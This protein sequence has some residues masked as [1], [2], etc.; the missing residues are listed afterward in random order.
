MVSVGETEGQ[1]GVTDDQAVS[2]Q[3]KSDW[4]K[5]DGD[6]KPWKL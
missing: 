2:G 4:R 6:G 1:T 3:A 5:V